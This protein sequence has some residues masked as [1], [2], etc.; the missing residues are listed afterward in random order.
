MLLAIQYYVNMIYMITSTSIKIC[1]TIFIIKQNRFR[2][3]ETSLLV[4]K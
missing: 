1:H 4:Y 2:P 3:N